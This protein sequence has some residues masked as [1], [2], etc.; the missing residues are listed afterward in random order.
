M[1]HINANIFSA[2]FL[3]E[4]QFIYKKR[5]FQFKENNW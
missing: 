4:A 3:L 1:W 2:A 5:Y